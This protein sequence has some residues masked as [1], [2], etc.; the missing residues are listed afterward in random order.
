[1]GFQCFKTTACLIRKR[2]IL[3]CDPIP[4]RGVSRARPSTGGSVYCPPFTETP[5]LKDRPRVVIVSHLCPFPP[6]HGNRSR[7]V[8]LLEWFRA[9]GIGVTFVLQPLDVEDGEG[10]SCLRD[11]VDRL[12]V[13][14]PHGA[15]RRAA[16]WARRGCA[17]LA[18]AILPNAPRRLLNRVL[19]GSRAQLPL[20]RQGRGTGGARGDSHI[21]EWCWPAT[22]RAVERVVRR[23]RPM[24]VFAEYALL[25]KCF[26]GLPPDVLKVIDTVEV[27]FRNRDRFLTAGL[28]APRICSAESEMLALGRADLLIAIQRNDAQA[29]THHFPRARV[30][31]V[32]HAYRHVPRRQRGP[33]RGSVLYVASSNPFNVHGLRDFTTHAWPLITARAPFA[34]LRVV[35]SVPP[36]SHAGAVRVL[37]VGRVSDVELAREYQAAHV[38]INPQVAGTGLK[39]KCVEALSAGCPLV[40]NRA[41]ADGLEE[42]EGR[43]FVVAADW[44]EFAD[45]VV[46]ILTDDR[47]RLVLESEAR[48]FAERL[49]SPEATFSELAVALTHTRS[50]V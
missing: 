6:L 30:I 21:D 44:E 33:E 17:S 40:M 12:E 2:V 18:R 5:V 3:V 50:P 23:D 13:V 31:T 37:H 49:F 46:A 28:A 15:G 34:T 14:R 9:S 42:G 24:A 36:D 25:T 35:G 48:A 32:P 11:L 41:G 4:P 38:V 10:L 16:A 43:A 27:F 47:R 19:G 1:M 22:C 29:L 26:E 45:Q 7:F 39:I 8:G 20:L